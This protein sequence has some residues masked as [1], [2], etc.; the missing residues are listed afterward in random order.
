MRFAAAG[1]CIL[2]GMCASFQSRFPLRESLRLGDLD[3]LRPLLAMG[4]RL[5][6]RLRDPAGGDLR[7]ERLSERERPPPPPPPRRGE[8]ERLLDLDRLRR[9]EFLRE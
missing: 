1:T 2:R 4:D 7:G 3:P 6:E 8:N 9:E 5:R